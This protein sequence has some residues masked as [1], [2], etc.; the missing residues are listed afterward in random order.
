M[1]GKS[2]KCV[3]FKPKKKMKINKKKFGAIDMPIQLEVV[4]ESI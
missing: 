2:I 1:S 4:Y 3:N